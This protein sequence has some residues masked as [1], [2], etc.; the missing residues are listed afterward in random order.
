MKVKE[1]KSK[2]TE[3]LKKIIAEARENLLVLKMQRADRKL[4]KV[5]D[6]R[7]SKQLIARSLTIIGEKEKE[8]MSK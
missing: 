7:K 8:N 5:A 3:E 2:T 4:K 6:F 1:L